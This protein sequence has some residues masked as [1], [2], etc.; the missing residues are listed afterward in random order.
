MQVKAIK[1]KK[2]EIGDKL[3]DILEESLPKEIEDR[4]IFAI[5][6]K[7]V[8][9]TEGR[10]VKNTSEDLRDE[11]AVKEADYYIPREYSQYGFMITITNGILVA[12][13]GIDRSNSAGYL[14]LW[15]KDPQKSANEIRE[16]L[17]K[18][19]QKQN[20]G[21]IITD[22]RVLPLRWGVTGV[23]IAHSGFKALKSYIGEPDLFGRIMQVEKTSIIDSLATASTV[24]T[25]EGNEQTP[26]S[27]I[28]DIPFVEFQKRNPTQEELG[29]L[30]IEIGDDVFSSLL[31]NDK[32]VKGGGG[33]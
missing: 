14:S 13:A 17:V 30:K 11:L 28:T 7:I 24:V 21:V 1:T 23:A 27:L 20:I 10:V 9:I 4:T 3:F 18:K 25:G 31:D 19:Y 15:P 16:F 22:S 26:I 8:G 2:V 32:W 33:E 6:S 12:S 5:A 29:D